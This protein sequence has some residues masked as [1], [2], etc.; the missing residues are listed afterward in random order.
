MGSG[1]GRETE[2]RRKK[3]KKRD[4]EIGKMNVRPCFLANSFSRTLGIRSLAL[5]LSH[6]FSL[7]GARCFELGEKRG[8][9]ALFLYCVSLILCF[10]NVFT[11]FFF[12]FFFGRGVVKAGAR[13]FRVATVRLTT[14]RS[15][16]RLRTGPFFVE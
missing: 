10:E 1:N 16:W 9:L 6:S 4:S 8:D 15:T 3:K 11:R 14:R 13:S 12:S 2:A 7:E 5:S